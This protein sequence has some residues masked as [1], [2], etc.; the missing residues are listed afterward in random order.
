MPTRLDRDFQQGAGM[1]SAASD[2]GPYIS[3]GG[4]MLVDR[5][6]HLV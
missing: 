2:I 5:R 1:R 6:P 4:K 3:F